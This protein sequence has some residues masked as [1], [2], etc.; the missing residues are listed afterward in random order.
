MSERSIVPIEPTAAYT[1]HETAELLDTSDRTVERQIAAGK[2]KVG[3]ASPR[4]R[5][6]TGA[7]ILKML[8]EGIA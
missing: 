7:N 5:R 6:I 1:I 8:E 4:R 3:Y 2:L